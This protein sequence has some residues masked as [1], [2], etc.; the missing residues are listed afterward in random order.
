MNSPTPKWDP[1]GVDRHSH[2]A[3]DQCHGLGPATGG[4]LRQEVTAVCR[5]TVDGQNPFRTTL[6]LWETI[7]YW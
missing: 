1:S 3:S 2:F 7:V 6:K 4:S 5:K